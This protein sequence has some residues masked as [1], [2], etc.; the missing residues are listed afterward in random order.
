MR[1]STCAADVRRLRRKATGTYA[2]LQLEYDF[3]D[4]E[5]SLELSSAALLLSRAGFSLVR[6]A[7][8]S[9]SGCIRS[10]TG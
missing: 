3:R 6:R 10:I 2:T 1:K 9:G 4:R 5:Q 7:K 8:G